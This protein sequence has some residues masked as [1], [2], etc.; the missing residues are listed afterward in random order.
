METGET[1]ETIR[2]QGKQ[3]GDEGKQGETRRNIK[4]HIPNPHN[5]LYTFNER[6]V[7]LKMQNVVVLLETLA[8]R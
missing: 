4:K 6:V 8:R 7:S 2:K 1:R 5:I 3:E